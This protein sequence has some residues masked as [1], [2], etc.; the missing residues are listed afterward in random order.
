MEEHAP[1]T[2]IVTENANTEASDLTEN[3]DLLLD[4]PTV[5]QTVS[6]PD[7]SLVEKETATVD[8]VAEC[9]YSASVDAVNDISAIILEI[10]SDGKNNNKDAADEE[11]IVNKADVIQN[12]NTGS[13]EYITYDMYGD[14][15]L[16]IPTK[17]LTL[18]ERTRMYCLQKGFYLFF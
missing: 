7:V 2:L 14:R 15:E 10:T 17:A 11:K 9:I 16:T 18:A 6:E 12:E 4:T 3:V 1:V 8:S 5:T 13:I